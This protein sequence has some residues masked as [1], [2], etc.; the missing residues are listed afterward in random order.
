VLYEVA[1]SGEDEKRASNFVYTAVL[2]SFVLGV[3]GGTVGFVSAPL[4]AAALSQPQ[5]TGM[6]KLFAYALPLFLINK[7]AHGIL[8]A[9]RRMRLIA[10]VRIMRGGIILLYFLSA[11][12]SKASFVTIPYGFILAELLIVVLVL[13]A[14]FRTHRFAKPSVRRAKGLISFGWRAALSNVIGDINSRLDILVIGIFWNASIVGIYS[15]AAAVAKGLWLIP[16]AIQNVTNPLIVQLYS[17]GEKEKLHRTMD[18]LFRLGTSLF[19]MIGLAIIIYIKP[20]IG[21]CY[22]GQLDILGAAVPLYFL[23]PGVAIFCGVTMLGSAPSTS[24]GRPENALKTSFA[25]FG[26]NL[27]MNFALVPFF[28]SVG[29]ASATTVSL[30]VALIYFSYLCRKHLD[31]TVSLTKLSM[32]FSVICLLVVSVTVFENIVSH[33]IVLVTGL[34]IIIAILI[35]LGMIRKSDWSLIHS[36][37]KSFTKSQKQPVM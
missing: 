5:M 26:V 15:V 32:L 17:S 18:V 35:L 27:L 13:T 37:L 3:L 19:I 25:V 4:I 6:L 21:L 23:L 24:I 30:L 29:A 1:A 28:A 16:G 14:C 33:L 9:H 2:S 11:A 22:P 12:I 36:A 31:F 10:G 8:N 34:V 20:L 7:T